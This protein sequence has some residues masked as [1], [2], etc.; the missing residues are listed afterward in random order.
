MYLLERFQMYHFR[1]AWMAARA[2][3]M[4]FNKKLYT[5]EDKSEIN[6]PLWYFPLVTTDRSL[7]IIDHYMQDCI[8][9]VAT[10]SRT[11]SRFDFRYE[12]MKELGFMSLVNE[13]HHHYS[14]I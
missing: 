11:K 10:G 5:S 13:F 8:R 3:I 4:H 9:Y 6:W 1:Y 12:Q 2:F 14:K 7:R